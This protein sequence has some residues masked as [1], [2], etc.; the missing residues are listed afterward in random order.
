MASGRSIAKLPTFETISSGSLAVPEGVVELLALGLGV[1]PVISG[2]FRPWP[3]SEV[4]ELRDVLAD[5]QHACPGRV[6]SRSA[7]GPRRASP[8]S[9]R[10][11]GTCRGRRRRR[12]RTSCTRV[13]RHA[14]LDAGRLR[15]EA[16]PLEH[17]PRHVEALG[18]DQAE[19]LV[20]L[21]VLAHEGRRQAEAPARL[22]VGGDAEDGR[23][24]QV[25]L[26]VDDEAP[27]LAGEQAEVLE[28]VRLACAATSA[29]GRC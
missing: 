19:D 9:P 21:A 23:R 22:Q 18:P 27:V 5:D 16:L 29:S 8:G 2:A 11:R 1:L 10:R 20:L 25:H 6:A 7:G 12:T 3:R 26:V 15:D 17:L 13:E 28:V 24:E 14:D 4:L